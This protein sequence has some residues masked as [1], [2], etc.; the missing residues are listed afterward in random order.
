MPDDRPCSGRRHREAPTP[1][2]S[3]HPIA[4]LCNRTDA[5]ILRQCS[6][7][8]QVSLEHTVYHFGINLEKRHIIFLIIAFNLAPQSCLNT[9]DVMLAYLH[10]D[11]VVVQDID[12]PYDPAPPKVYRAVRHATH[13]C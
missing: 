3:D 8:S 4:G 2:E 10:R 1:P 11:L 6:V 12:L 9:V 13:G 7:N 5:D